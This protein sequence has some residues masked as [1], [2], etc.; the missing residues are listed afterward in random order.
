MMRAVLL[1]AAAVL[2][3]ASAAAAL[4]S[5]A[6]PSAAT[7]SCAG[8]GPNHA[9]IVV[10]HGSGSVVTRCVAFGGETISGQQLLE[11]SGIAWSGQTFGGFGVAVCA[12]DGEPAS[13][14]SCPGADSYWAVFVSR[15]GAAW[16]LTAVGVSGLTLRDGD[17]E[18][19]RYVPT[20]GTPSSPTLPPGVCAAATPASSHPMPSPST[21][22]AAT[23]A[24]SLVPSAAGSGGSPQP[25]LSP[26]ASGTASR[27]LPTPA[28]PI[29]P[30]G[31]E[32]GLDPGLL[33]AAA[34]AGGLAGLAI[35][36]VAAMRRRPK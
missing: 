21:G 33:A 31:P 35:L 12:L 34:A 14:T 18:G 27:P 36:L 16:Q 1:R 19:L 26:A 5:L 22:G 29:G 17:L 32:A 23:L 3:V 7:Q 9:A 11:Q 2:A 4:A 28:P 25:S 10:Q 6:P 13:Y 30:I 24:S 20:S 8:A 15:G